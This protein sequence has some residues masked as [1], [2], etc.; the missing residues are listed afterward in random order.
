VQLEQDSADEIENCV[1]L[2]ASVPKGSLIDEPE[3]G[4]TDPTFMIRPRVNLIAAQMHEWEPR[5]QVIAVEAPVGEDMTLAN[6]VVRVVTGT[7]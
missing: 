6:I 4:I 1:A 2:I 5:A 3:F 7:P